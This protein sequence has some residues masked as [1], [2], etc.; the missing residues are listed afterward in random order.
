[1]KNN[2]HIFE[3]AYWAGRLINMPDS[4]MAWDIAN[5]ISSELKHQ[6]SQLKEERNKAIDD[7]IEK[8]N[9]RELSGLWVKSEIIDTLESLKSK[10]E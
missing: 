8:F 2:D 3:S 9:M 4:K 10:P 1:M 7:A 6:R 5:E